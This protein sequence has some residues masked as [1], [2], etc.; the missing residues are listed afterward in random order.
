MSDALLQSYKDKCFFEERTVE[1]YDE[2]VK[3]YQLIQDLKL[4][5]K[6]LNRT[7]SEAEYHYD[8]LDSAYD[9]LYLK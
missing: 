6:E 1:I 7:L 4:Q 2:L 8:Q 3:Q 5:C 9:L